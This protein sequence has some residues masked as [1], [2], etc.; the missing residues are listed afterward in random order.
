MGCAICSGSSSSCS[1]CQ[2]SYFLQNSTCLACD[3]TCLTCNG[4][5]MNDCIECSDNLLLYNS[6]CIHDCPQGYIISSFH[7]CAIKCGDGFIFD[8]PDFCNDGNS[9]DGDG[10]SSTCHIEEGFQILNVSGNITIQKEIIPRFNI[11]LP[12]QNNIF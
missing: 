3:S 8:G 4:V 12:N 2:Q 11:T 10:C 5:S 7:T 9:I 6:T 1:K